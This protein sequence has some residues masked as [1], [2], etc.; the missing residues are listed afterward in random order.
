MLTLS[1]QGIRANKGLSGPGNYY[2]EAA[3]LE[4]GPV[5]IGWATNFADIEPVGC[6]EGGISV[7]ILPSDGQNTRTCTLLVGNEAQ[8]PVTIDEMP[9]KLVVDDIVGCLIHRQPNGDT[10]LQWAVNGQPLLSPSQPIQLPEGMRE[11]A[12]FPGDES[13]LNRDVHTVFTNMS[14]SF[15]SIF[16]FFIQQ[17]ACWT[18]VWKQTLEIP[19]FVILRKVELYIQMENPLLRML[20]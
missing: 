15:L 7:G 6:D 19:H 16:P 17:S 3:I 20:H 9:R 8:I 12:I 4:E 18:V 13:K 14:S 2:Y 11:K 5:L 1:F 10:T